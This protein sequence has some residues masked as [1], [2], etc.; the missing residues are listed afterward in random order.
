MST[1]RY[2]YLLAV[3]VLLAASCREEKLKTYSGDNYIHFSYMKDRSPQKIEFNFATEAPLATS[4]EVNAEMSLW[5]YL[6]DK[7][8][9]IGVSTIDELTTGSKDK[10]YF[11]PTN[12]VFKKGLAKDFYKFEVRREKELLETDYT[13]ALHLDSAEGCI[14]EPKEFSIVI[15][16]ITDRVSEP[17]WWKQSIASRLGP[18]YDIKYRLF[19]IFMN[20]KILKNLDEYS[21]I[22]FAN[23]VSAF[24]ERWKEEWGKGNWKY[25]CEDG[26]TPMYETIK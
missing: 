12:S 6:L 10:D 11:L 17:V 23:I 21:G 19:I 3:T 7:D 18:Y 20:G 4:A 15:V 22:Q 24:K 2:I 14:C 26:E 1:L 16:H 25:Y 8:V 13:V 9:K 5:G